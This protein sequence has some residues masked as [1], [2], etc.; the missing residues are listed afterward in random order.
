MSRR[1]P[2]F[3]TAGPGRLLLWAG[4]AATTV[5]AVV[6]AE[7]VLEPRRLITREVALRL[8]RWPATF[9]GLRVA[10]VAD[11]HV[12]S[13][14]VPLAR[15]AEVVRRV[16][17]ARPELVLLL[18]D[19]LAD[20]RHGPNID[21][22]AVAGA[23]AP[24]LDVAPHAAVLGNHDWYA[25]GYRVRAAFEDAGFT[26]LEESSCVVDVRGRPLYL[27]GVAD[28]WERRPDVAAALADV[29]DTAPVLLLSHNPDCVLD[30]PPR[31]ALTVSGHTHAGQV[32]PFRRPLYTISPTTGNRFVRG[33]YDVPA[34]GPAG[35]LAVRPLYVSPG[36]GTSTLPWR[37][38]VVPE[39]TVLRL[40]AP[41]A[42]CTPPG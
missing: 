14:G 29:P 27:A 37:V 5:L 17:A 23:L 22:G 7:A 33:R 21:P 4:I 41:L 30:A 11:L 9:D 24:L 13:P 10:V 39:I 32:A 15:V 3:A 12:G 34:G 42:A 38:G 19:Y 1:R 26:V 31:I 18:G 2:G 20:V 6:A 40:W 16:R 36:V 25:G 8:P 28:L 35:D